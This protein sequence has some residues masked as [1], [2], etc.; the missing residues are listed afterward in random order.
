M[1]NFLLL[2]ILVLIVLVVSA[3]AQ[4]MLV[5]PAYQFAASSLD[6]T[7]DGQMVIQMQFNCIDEPEARIFIFT[8][9]MGMYLGELRLLPNGVIETYPFEYEVKSNE[10]YKKKGAKSSKAH[11]GG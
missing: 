3:K 8:Y 1:K 10:E 7:E 11:L 4:H 5:L 9:P 6:S 2:V